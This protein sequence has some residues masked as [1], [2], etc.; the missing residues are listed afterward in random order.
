MIAHVVPLTRLPARCSFFD[1]RIPEGMTV[2][3]GDLVHV[4]FRGVA[5]LGIVIALAP[6]SEQK[7]LANI[8]S[9]QESHYVT[10]EHLALLTRISEHIGQSLASLLVATVPAST[11]NTSPTLPSHTATRTITLKEEDKALLTRIGAFLKHQHQAALQGDQETGIALAFLLAKNL[12]TNE[13]LLLLVPRD[14]DAE[15]LTRVIAHP[16]T[17][18]ITGTTP[19]RARSL[20]AAAWKSGACNVL[21]ATKQGALWEPKNLKHVLVLQAGNDE[22]S[23]LRRNPK[24]DPREA[25]RLVATAHGANYISIDTLPRIEDC[26]HADNLLLEGAPPV[27]PTIVSL[28]DRTEKTPHPLLTASLLEAIKTAS[29]SQKK[30]LLFL[31]RKGAAKRLQ[32]TACGETPL[33]ATCGNLPTVRANDL[34]CSRCGVEMWIPSECPL[35]GKPKLKFVGVGG[36]KVTHDL[37]T[38]FPQESVGMI[39]KSNDAAWK[40]AN[41]L[42]A[43]EHVFANLLTP[44]TRMNFGLVADLMAD[45][46][47]GGTDF[48]ALEHTSRQALR[49]LA[50]AKREQAQC[51]F[52]TWIP[53]RFPDVLAP[54][55]IIEEERKIRTRYQLPPFGTIIATKDRTL[56]NPQELPQESFTYDGTY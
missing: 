16:K 47:V 22:Y 23:N 10:S 55:F 32:C 1:Y 5:V 36:E 34:V 37:Q 50:L 44:F 45:L 21:I 27:T 12:T 48:R 31:N 28:K 9:V 11:A 39:E 6:E 7:K 53:E 42:V 41:I 35:C 43:T 49:L 8:T 40:T 18:V 17:G 38:L 13:Q 54:A 56:R 29:Q 2:T 33:C 15:L 25:A 4:P 3:L 19:Q 24:F 30:V 51:I 46:P 20:L 52:Q 14:R 26:T